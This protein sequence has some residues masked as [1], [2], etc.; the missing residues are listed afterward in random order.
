MPEGFLSL[1]NSVIRG[2]KD[3]TFSS[4]TI[5][6]VLCEEAASL[7]RSARC[8][9]IRLLI[10]YRRDSFFGKEKGSAATNDAG[11]NDH[12]LFVHL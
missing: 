3:D 9:L 12:D 7:S 11:T 8:Y 2:G 5:A 6:P 10:D 4:L 1:S